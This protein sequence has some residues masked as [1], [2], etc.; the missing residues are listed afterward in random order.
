MTVIKIFNF[1]PTLTGLSGKN[2]YKENITTNVIFE[3]TE[4][5]LLG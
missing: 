5:L 4:T 3:I 2:F 1:N